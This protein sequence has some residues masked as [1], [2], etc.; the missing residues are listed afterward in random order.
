[1]PNRFIQGR[2]K[3]RRMENEEVNRNNRKRLFLASKRRE[4]GEEAG[5]MS[6]EVDADFWTSLPPLQSSESLLSSFTIPCRGEK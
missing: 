6:E 5:E 2:E 1:M 4:G 3:T